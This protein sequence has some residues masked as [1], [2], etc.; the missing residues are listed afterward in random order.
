MCD[1]T[2]LACTDELI[3]SQQE[4]PQLSLIHNHVEQGTLLPKCPPGLWKC[5]IR[6]GILCCSY[7]ESSTGTVRVQIVVPDVLKDTIMRETHGLGHLGIKK[8]LDTIRTKFY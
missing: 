1:S 6:D 2:F 7:K 8:T 5:L 3:Q 4:D